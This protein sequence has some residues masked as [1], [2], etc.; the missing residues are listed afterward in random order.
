MPQILTD[1]TRGIMQLPVTPKK[2]CLW[3]SPFNSFSTL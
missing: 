3:K 2:A 1:D